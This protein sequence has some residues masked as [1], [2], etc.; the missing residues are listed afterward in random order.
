[1]KFKKRLNIHRFWKKKM[2]IQ[3]LEFKCSEIKM[4]SKKSK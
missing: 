4:K 1:M 3:N 2:K